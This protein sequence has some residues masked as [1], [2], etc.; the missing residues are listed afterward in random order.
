MRSGAGSSDRG[1]PARAHVLLVGVDGFEH[2]IVEILA[3]SV[4]VTKVEEAA[5]E[6]F[7]QKKHDVAVVPPAA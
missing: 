4:A 5:F 1:G 3:G 2:G 7:C 6:F